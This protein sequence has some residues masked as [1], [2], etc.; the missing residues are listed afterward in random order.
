MN[1]LTLMIG[2]LGL[3]TLGAFVLL[4]TSNTYATCACDKAK[5]VQECRERNSV[6]IFCS[7]SEQEGCAARRDLYCQ[8]SA[9]Q[10]PGCEKK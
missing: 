6:T 9:C 7:P 2:R 4:I 8:R 3:V 10:D 5:E 1:K